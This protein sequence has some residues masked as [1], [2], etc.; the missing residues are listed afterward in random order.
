[1]TTIT[2]TTPKANRQ[3][4]ALAFGQNQTAIRFLE[5]M[6]EDISLNL[7]D[8]IQATGESSQ[9]LQVLVN[10][11]VAVPRLPDPFSRMLCES[12]VARQPDRN[13]MLARLES[14]AFVAQ[15]P[16]NYRAQSGTYQQASTTGT[17]LSTGTTANAASILLSAGAWDI[18]GVCV[19]NPASTT[20]IEQLTA[21]AATVSATLGTPDTYQQIPEALSTSAPVN[22]EAPL[23]R[24]VLASAAT[25]Y[26]VAQAVFVTST[27]T[28]DGYIKAR[29][30]L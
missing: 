21:G 29:P 4:L 8:A 22:L 1:M 30:G 16:G 26:L 28:V 10:G 11:Q 25:V 7:P 27:M 12:A 13:G 18:S 9:F 20:V 5:A 24:I 3:M 15:P 23:T 6:A 14:A 17:S 19:F 2:I